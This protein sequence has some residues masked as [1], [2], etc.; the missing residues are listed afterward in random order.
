MALNYQDRERLVIGMEELR[1]TL[2]KDGLNPADKLSQTGP[3]CA[4]AIKLPKTKIHELPEI[5][6]LSASLYRTENNRQLVAQIEGSPSE[7]LRQLLK[8][9]IPILQSLGINERF[10]RLCNDSPNAISGYCSDPEEPG[11]ERFRAFTIDYK[12]EREEQARRKSIREP[13]IDETISGYADA[14]IDEIRWWQE[15][16][17][18]KLF[19]RQKTTQQI[20]RENNNHLTLEEIRKRT[21]IVLE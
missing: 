16:E 1:Q 2:K 12:K 15:S 7:V 9:L 14:T 4:A 8:R 5:R 3:N 19:E 17:L 18:R 11:T 21:G 10:N 20:L 6:P 13:S